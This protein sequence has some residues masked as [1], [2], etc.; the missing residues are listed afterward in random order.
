M[1]LPGEGHADDRVLP[2]TR[3]ASLAVVA[4]LIPA[5]VV[6][7]GFPH[8]TADLWSWEVHPAMTPIFMGAGYGG[9]AYFF[10][11]V[12]R[13]QRWHPAS[14]GVL[15]AAVFAALELIV[16]IAHWDGFNRGDAPALGAIA[17]YGW[18][19]VYIL[20]PFA[21]GALWWLNHRRDPRRP[22]AGDPIVPRAARIVAAAIG[23]GAVT[24]GVVF[25][26]SPGTASDLWPWALKPLAA[27]VI[28]CFVI[29]V[30]LGA[31]LLALDARWSAWRLLLETVLV[32]TAL[33][34]VGVAREWGDFDAGDSS[35]WL[36]LGG[37]AGLAAAVVLLL[38]RMRSAR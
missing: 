23:I 24:S 34:L 11:R 25:L 6:L 3:W 29:Q 14:A 12:F 30:G 22:E 18:V 15:S 20:S 4:I 19:S 31:L 9:G 38:A 13:S 37:L 16:T 28:A 32:A 35:T 21:V 27:R 8:D 17:Y 5:V 10:F 33:M 2:A 36:F 26:I 7:W 1:P